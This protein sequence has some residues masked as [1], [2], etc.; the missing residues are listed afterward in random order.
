M[1]VAG[2]IAVWAYARGFPVH[3]SQSQIWHQES[4]CFLLV[5]SSWASIV[6]SAT[7][8]AQLARPMIIER[9]LCTC[10]MA[11]HDWNVNLRLRTKLFVD[12]LYDIHT[13]CFDS[14][15]GGM[16]LGFWSNVFYAWIPRPT[17]WSLVEVQQTL[18]FKPIVKWYN[19]S[20]RNTLVRR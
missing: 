3:C 10:S 2:Q 20:Y 7:R 1:G 8:K 11:F 16:S 17:T 15:T 4:T 9:Y 6:T 18:L 13:H 14:C 19:F 12:C 5:R